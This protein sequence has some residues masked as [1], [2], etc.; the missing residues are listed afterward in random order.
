MS[1]INPLLDTESSCLLIGMVHLPPLPG[2]AGWAGSMT[3]VLDRA[4]RDADALIEGGCDALLVENM[5]DAP[6]LKAQVRPETTAAMAVAVERI[7]RLGGPVGV[8]IL[9]GANREALGVAVATGARFIRVEAF[10][11]AHVADEGW[12]DAC[13]GE[14]IRARHNVCS[15]IEIW[16]DIQ[17]K[18]AAHGVTADLTI[19]DHAQ[20]AEFCGAD[21]LVV[22][23]RST[24]YRT[25]VND[26][27]A[28]KSAGLPVVVGSGIAV[29][30]VDDY[31]GLADAV[32]VGSSLKHQ[33]HWRNPVSPDRVAQL[34]ARIDD[35]LVRIGTTEDRNTSDHT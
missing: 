30:N 3:T 15:S 31:V 35:A 10:A 28:A 26:V 16:A 18:H 34:R 12:M 2:S 24:G 14:L 8:Q 27:V 17:K 6:Y 25:T 13:A 21:A 5:G 7:V 32:I 11:Y 4:Q 33:G 29:D 1:R 9:A 20:G 22:T 23:G 19:E